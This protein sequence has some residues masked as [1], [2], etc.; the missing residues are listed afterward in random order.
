[1]DE[2]NIKGAGPA[3]LILGLQLQDMGVQTTIKERKNSIKTT[4]CGGG[5]DLE[6]LEYLKKIA[7][8][9]SSP[10]IMRKFKGFKLNFPRRLYS[11]RNKEGCVL[12]RQSWLEGMADEF[13]ARG[14]VIEYGSDGLGCNIDCSGPKEGLVAVEHIIDG[15]YDCGYLEFYLNKEFTDYYAW[16]FPW[17]DTTNVGLVGTVS[18]LNKYLS[19]LRQDGI[20]GEVLETHGGM[21]PSGNHRLWEG[22]T[23]YL[24]DSAGMCNPLTLGGIGPII[25]ASEILADNLDKPED[26]LKGVMSHDINHQSIYDF[27]EI[28]T[29]M[30]NHELVTIGKVLD[31]LETKIGFMS[32]LRS[33][34][35]PRLIPKLLTMNKAMEVSMK[36][37]W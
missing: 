1:M 10:Y 16:V 6:G 8:F 27:T 14:G 11:Y 23:F 15:V 2:A 35:N 7:H 33:L 19:W 34:R 25:Y 9:D 26:Y 22:G 36:Y 31:R 12:D 28:Y 18:Q 20:D 24:G 13:Q 37:G 32:A 30:P 4:A 5:M 29:S 3:G 17:K 21:I